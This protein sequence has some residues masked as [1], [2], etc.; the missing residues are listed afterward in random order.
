MTTGDI[1]N[2]LADICG[3]EVSRDLVSRMTDAVIEDMQQRQS[4]SLDACIRSC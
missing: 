1:A 4:R 2:H 3:A